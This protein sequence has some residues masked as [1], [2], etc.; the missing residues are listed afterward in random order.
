MR[1]GTTTT[2]TAATIATWRPFAHRRQIQFEYFTHWCDVA[3]VDGCVAVA[4]ED[5]NKRSACLDAL[6]V[7]LHAERMQQRRSR[8]V[9]N[10]N[11][12]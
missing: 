8:P 4:E 11:K 9:L 6:S 5:S 10:V 2:T 12:K 1:L 7:V 3:V